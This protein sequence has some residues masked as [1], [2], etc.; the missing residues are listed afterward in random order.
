MARRDASTM[1]NRRSEYCSEQSQHRPQCTAIYQGRSNSVSGEAEPED[2]K[3]DNQLSTESNPIE[4]GADSDGLLVSASSSG[5][6]E[7][8]QSV[9]TLIE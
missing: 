3:N 1:K 2:G 6:G 9:N 5:G 7:S 8:L 4:I